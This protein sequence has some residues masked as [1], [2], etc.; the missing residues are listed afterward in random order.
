MTFPGIFLIAIF[1]VSVAANI[2][3][4][5]VHHPKVFSSFNISANPEV[6]DSSKLPL[7]KKTELTEKFRQL[8]D[9]QNQDGWVQKVD[10]V[11]QFVNTNSLHAIDDA[12]GDHA[13]F[14]NQTLSMIYDHHA[15]LGE[16]PHLSCGPRAR[17]MQWI[18]VQLGITSREVQVYSDASD[19]I[20][21]H[22]FL[23]VLNPESGHW[24]AQDPD[25]DVYY[26][27]KRTNQR[28][29]AYELVFGDLKNYI[30][31]TTATICGWQQAGVGR[32]RD[33]NYFMAARFPGVGNASAFLVNISRYSADKE[34]PGNSGQ[35]FGQF[36][37][38]TYD[39][40]TLVT[41]GVTKLIENSLF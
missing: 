25:Y 19:S 24:E 7:Y 5:V 32:L 39:G 13:I 40:A 27:D 33:M 38:K 12:W 8:L 10:F 41:L 17:A 36:A 11:R 21:S 22:T 23:D 2:G 1:T 31:C 35:T 30:P 20:Q 3:F 16:P 9:E 14:I 37:L 4:I 15:G 18:L 29:S 6:E 26:K 34:Y 28:V